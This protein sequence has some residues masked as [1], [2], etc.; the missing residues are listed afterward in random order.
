MRTLLRVEHLTKDF[1]THGGET[2]RAVDD[3]SF[4][5]GLHEKMAVIGESG[6]GKTTL[7]RMITRLTEA[8][9]GQIFLEEENITRAKGH[10]LR[11]IYQKMQMVFQ[12]PMESFDPRR[13]LGDGIGESLRNMGISHRETRER[14]E[15]LLEKCGLEKEFADRYPHQVSGGQCQRAAIARALAVDPEILICDEA[16]SA[17]DVT[18]QKQIL[19][20]LI[21]LKEKENLSFLLICHDLALVQALCDKVLVLYHGKTVEYGSPDEIIDHPKMDYTKRLIESVL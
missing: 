2:Y 1:S 3:V 18:V 17:L 19:E 7:A 10:N 15:N 12:M 11:N 21:E 4:S 13:T 8:T 5:L 20:L 6:S 16:T 14:V 9:S